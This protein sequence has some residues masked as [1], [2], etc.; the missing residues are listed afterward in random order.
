M[1]E[2]GDTQNAH[3]IDRAELRR[4][5]VTASTKRRL[6]ELER[7]QHQI[8]DEGKLASIPLYYAIGRDEKAD[9]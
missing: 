1:A 9:G 4:A 8:A 7:L 5:L 2:N 6:S 3:Q